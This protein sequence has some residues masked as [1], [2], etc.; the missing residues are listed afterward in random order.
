MAKARKPGPKKRNS[1]NELKNSTRIKNN[2]LVLREIKKRLK[3]LFYG[4]KTNVS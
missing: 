4:L 2:L 1:K 3:P